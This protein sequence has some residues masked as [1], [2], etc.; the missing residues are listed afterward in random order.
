MVKR[1]R[2]RLNQPFPSMTEE[3]ALGERGLKA[4][5]AFIRKINVLDS[6]PPLLACIV[7]GNVGHALPQSCKNDSTQP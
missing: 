1:Q 3:R 4:E 7:K 5:V 2:E 6:K